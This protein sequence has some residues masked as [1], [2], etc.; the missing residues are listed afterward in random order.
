ME[1][2]D[3]RLAREMMWDR[4]EAQR[5]A[6]LGRDWNRRGVFLSREEQWWEIP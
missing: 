4:I 2:R 5:K 6:E 3:G 1:S